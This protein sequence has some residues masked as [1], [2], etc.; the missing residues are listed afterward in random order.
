[1]RL[2]QSMPFVCTSPHALTCGVHVERDPRRV[3]GD[4]PSRLADEKVGGVHAREGVA[5]T[6]HISPRV[7]VQV[8]PAALGGALVGGWE[9]MLPVALA[10]GT[11]H[12]A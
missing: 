10:P 8:N 2:D 7:V 9:L 4:H 12:H 5:N 6:P 1:M 11:N 3:R